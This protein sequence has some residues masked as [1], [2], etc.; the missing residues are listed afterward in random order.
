MT[1]AVDQIQA[2]REALEPIQVRPPMLPTLAAAALT[3][4]AAILLAGVMVLGT[5]VAIEDPAP[6]SADF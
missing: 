6:I 1:T 2:A 5:G 4:T 3:A